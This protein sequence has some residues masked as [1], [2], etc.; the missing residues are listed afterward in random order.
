MPV[1]LTSLEIENVKR[2]RAV[3]M[4]LGPG[5]TVIGGDN[6]QGKT[7]I[8]DA[9]AY[10]LGGEKRRPTN[11]QHEGGL[12]PARIDITLSNGLHVERAGKNAALKVTDPSGARQGQR[13]LDAFVEELALDLPKFLAMS[14]RDKAAVLLRI[15]GIGDKLAALDR[16]EKALYDERTTTGRVADQKAKYAAELPEHHDVPEIPVSAADLVRESQA[17]MARNAERQAARNRI[18]ELQAAHGRAEANVLALSQRIADLQNQLAKAQD[19]VAAALDALNDAKLPVDSDESTADI[20]RRMDELETVNAKVRQNLDKAKA[21]EEARDL[22]TA[23][24]ALTAKIEDV[25][26]RRAALLDGAGMPLPGLSV[27]GGA[28]TYRGKAW[29]CM[30]KSE[31]IKAAVAIVRKLRPEC[32]FV[33]IDELECLDTTQ[34][35]AF[36]AWLEAEGLQAITTRVSRGDECTFVIEDG[37]I[38]TGT[39]PAAEELNLA[40]W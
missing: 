36:G 22:A 33:L 34:L 5:L 9:I 16:E 23:Y 32:G 20:Q 19:E 21:T 31:Q 30:A 29:D 37:A 27:E 8:L 14:D 28:L 17:V 12:A 7:T 25:R 40:K 10:A 11:L 3:A 38:A 26:T 13:L 6:G 4:P 1:T 15:L 2:V 39:A 35:A 18:R 24:G